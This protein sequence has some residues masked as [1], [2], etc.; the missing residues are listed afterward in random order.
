M[1]G[2]QYGAQNSGL[3]NGEQV[4]TVGR[5]SGRPYFDE[6]WNVD[7]DF[8]GEYVFHPNINLAGTPNVS[9]TTINLQD[10]PEDRAAD[11][12]RLISTGNPNIRNINDYGGETGISW[13]N[14]LGQGG[15][16]HIGENP[17][18]VGDTTCSHPQFPWGYVEG[19]WVLTGEPI[20][21]I[22]GSAA[23]ARAK[24]ASPFGLTESC[25]ETGIGAWEIGARWSVMDLNSNVTPGMS[26]SVT[27][28]VF[29]GLQQIF[30]VAL[31]WYPNDFVR[32]YLQF[33]YS[34]IDKLNSEGTEQIGQ[35]FETLAGRMH[36]AL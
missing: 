26:Q 23:F 31:S 30:G 35:H 27:G 18:G 32:F 24:V 17:S 13:R 7:P 15:Y 22:T 4:S 8:S 2:A 20:R 5:L 9:Q 21:Y 34:Q 10:R 25:F 19:G 3:L 36:V 16:Y 28:G 14:F 33:Q 29:G 1:T 6:D 12:N 11:Q